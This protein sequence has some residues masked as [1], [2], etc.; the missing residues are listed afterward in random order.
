[1]E[2]KKIQGTEGA[3]SSEP[4]KAHPTI[5]LWHKIV[6]MY[7]FVWPLACDRGQSVSTKF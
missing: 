7:C 3:H 5:L 2:D 1:M 4:Q 6:A